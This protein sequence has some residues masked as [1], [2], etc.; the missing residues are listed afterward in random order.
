MLPDGRRL[1]AH[2][3]L[4]GG[5]VRA[6]DRAHE[7]GAGAM[8]VFIDNPTAWRRRT[9]PPAEAEAFRARLAEFDIAPIAVH[10]SYLVNLAGPEED[11]FGRSVGVLASDLRAAPGFLARYVNVHIG[12]HRGAGVAFGTKRLADGLALVLAEVDDAL[13]APAIVLENSA[14]SG[15]GLG[16]DVPGLAAIADA[17]DAR[18]IAHDRLGFCIDTAHAWAAGIDLSEPDEIDRF[19]ADFDARIG[20]DR[21]A[22]VH[23]NDSKTERGSHLDRHEHLGAGRIGVDGLG[24][25]LRHPSLAR[26]TYYLETPGMDEGYDA[27]NLARAHDIAARRPLADLPPEAMT[28]RGSRARTGPPLGPSDAAE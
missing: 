4:G 24:H 13:D 2:L 16:T 1:G 3:P 8:Q 15:F 22:M 18:G 20:L 11:S 21:L 6:V 28:M 14:G 25:L 9:D 17:A 19:L 7:I 26:A 27:V 12:S 10:A 5:M 23:L